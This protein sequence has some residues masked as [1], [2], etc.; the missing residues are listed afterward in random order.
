[1][2]RI[3]TSIAAQ[4]S[5][6]ASLINIDTLEVCGAIG[7]GSA[8]LP[9]ELPPPPQAASTALATPSA[10]IRDVFETMISSPLI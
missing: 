6:D 2:E 8:A 5:V 10:S 4:S 7:A 1:M 3:F 9:F